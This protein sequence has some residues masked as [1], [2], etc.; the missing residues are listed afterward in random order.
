MFNNYFPVVVVFVFGLIVS[1]ALLLIARYLGWRKPDWVKKQP[2]ECGMLPMQEASSIQFDVKFY[3]TALLFLIFDMET[4][5]VL[6]WAVGFQHFKLIGIA[7]FVYFEMLFFII[8]L[9][10]GYIYVWKRG[11]FSWS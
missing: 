1:S 6:I 3:L 5:F 11:G 2:F 9:M 10:I 8:V 4:I 7:G